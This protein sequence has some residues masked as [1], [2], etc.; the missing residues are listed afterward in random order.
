MI[1]IGPRPEKTVF[2]VSDKGKVKSV[3]ST[4]DI[5]YSLI[6]SN[7]NFAI[8]SGIF[9]GNVNTKKI[10]KIQEWALRF[11]Y[12]DYISSYDTL[13]CRAQLGLDAKKTV[14]GVVN[15]TGA[16]QPT[17]SRSLTSISSISFL[18][19]VICKLATGDISFF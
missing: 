9:V 8:S 6:M 7:F 11:I 10:E 3:S 16:D 13:L 17:H 19:I 15:N 1:R 5:Y 2:V 12:Q 4:T 18:E 14:S